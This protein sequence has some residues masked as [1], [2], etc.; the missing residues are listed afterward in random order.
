MMEY[1][2]MLTNFTSDSWCFHFSD[3]VKIECCNDMFLVIAQA[4]KRHVFYFEQDHFQLF[5]CSR[6]IGALP[7][8]SC[9]QLVQEVVSG[10]Q[11]KESACSGCLDPFAKEMLRL[12]MHDPCLGHDTT[13]EV[14]PLVDVASALVERAHLTAQDLKPKRSRGIAVATKRLCSESYRKSCIN[15]A[16]HSYEFVEGEALRK[17][18]LTRR[19]LHSLSKT[20]RLNRRSAESF[21]SKRTVTGTIKTGKTI[22][23]TRKTDPINLYRKAEWRLKGARVGTEAFNREQDRIKTAWHALSDVDKSVWVARAKQRDDALNAFQKDPTV[24]SLAAACAE[25]SPPPP[26]T[27]F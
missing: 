24:A 17:R 20:L 19:Q 8:T 7:Y 25:C 9:Q 4:W 3:A 16:K 1:T 5:R 18:G 23:R 6:G 10:L 15:E 22:S 11:E 21:R 14:L 27:A 13:K 2:T 12:F 26:P